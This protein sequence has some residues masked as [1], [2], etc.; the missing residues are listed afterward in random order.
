MKKKN[1]DTGVPPDKLL[2]YVKEKSDY[3]CA[4]GI[5][6]GYWEL[7]PGSEQFG[8]FYL[9]DGDDTIAIPCHA[10]ASVL[11]YR[12]TASTPRWYQVY[13]SLFKDQ[14]K[15]ALVSVLKTTP[16]QNNV[17][18]LRG[19]I[20]PSKKSKN[21]LKVKIIHRN[22]QKVLEVKHL[23]LNCSTLPKKFGF[24]SLTARLTPELSLEIVDGTPVFDLPLSLQPKI[25][26]PSIIKKKKS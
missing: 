3:F 7:T 23:L 16:K 4:L 21:K 25:N 12:D 26:F 10:F 6:Y 2:E 5:C 1:K 13:P 18:K 22:G 15:L 17:F 14:V 24:W 20:S 8:T 19:V 11:R 9:L